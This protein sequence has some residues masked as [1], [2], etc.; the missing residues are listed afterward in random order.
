MSGLHQCSVIGSQI[1]FY[2]TEQHFVGF[3]DNNQEPLV[4]S[5]RVQ[6]DK[7]GGA[8]NF[9]PLSRHDSGQYRCEAINDVGTDSMEGKVTVI[10]EFSRGCRPEGKHSFN[11]V[12]QEQF[13]LQGC[14]P[15]QIS[16][17]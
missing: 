17:I 16:L 3:Q 12:Y 5:E 8:V 13:C 9:R 7:D 2:L 10:G 14:L 4:H 11:H 6:L 1:C 15:D